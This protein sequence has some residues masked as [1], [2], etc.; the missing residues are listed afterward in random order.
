[1]IIYDT[2]EKSINSFVS[3]IEPCWTYPCCL[4]LIPYS[5]CSNRFLPKITLN[6]TMLYICTETT[7]AF[8][9][10]RK[11]KNESHWFLSL[12][13]KLQQEKS[14]TQGL[15]FYDEIK[16]HTGGKLFINLSDQIFSLV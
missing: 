12:R 2:K 3:R 9:Q 4:C 11:F 5:A 8:V 15:V 13:V 14:N 16:L 1:M 7:H 6:N 10:E